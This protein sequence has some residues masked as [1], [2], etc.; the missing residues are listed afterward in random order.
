MN[1][2]TIAAYAA[3]LLTA[4]VIYLLATVGEWWSDG[5]HGDKA[6]CVICGKPPTGRSV[7]RECIE[8]FLQDGE[9]AGSPTEGREP[10]EA[11]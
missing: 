10:P 9:S 6:G 8:A 7:C 11:A 4:L 2:L 3:G 1:W 5:V